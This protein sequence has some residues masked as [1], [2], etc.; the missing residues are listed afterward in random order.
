MEDFP[1]SLDLPVLDNHPIRFISASKGRSAAINSEGELFVWGYKLTHV[2][3][4]IDP[5][6][7]DN[8]KVTK[9][10][11]GGESRNLSMSVLT[12][13]G[14]LWTFGD[15]SSNMLG[16]PRQSGQNPTPM[17]V[18]TLDKKVL[19]IFMGTGL[20]MCALVDIEDK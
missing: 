4:K 6:V 3:T 16:R 8:R 18:K 10:C 14:A 7:F 20:H 13:D 9:V 2:P 19:D 1:R 11:L 12:E 17:K 15:A 5:S